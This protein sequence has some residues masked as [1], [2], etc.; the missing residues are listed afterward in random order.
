MLKKALGI[1]EEAGY[2]EEM[3]TDWIDDAQENFADKVGNYLEEETNYWHPSS[4]TRT[5]SGTEFFFP[6]GLT[7]A[8]EKHT[9]KW[10]LET[11]DELFPLASDSPLEMGKEVDALLRAGGY[12]LQLRD[13]EIKW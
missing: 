9:G 7:I 1:L 10:F 11:D 8:V 12:D 2:V 5:D 6:M 4:R 13:T 3:V